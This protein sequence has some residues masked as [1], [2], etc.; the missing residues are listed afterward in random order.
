MLI[1]VATA[2]AMVSPSLAK[3]KGA[4]YALISKIWMNQMPLRKLHVGVQ[5]YCEN[6]A[7]HG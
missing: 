7:D 1:P 4:A 5:Q 6:V 3:K 2:V